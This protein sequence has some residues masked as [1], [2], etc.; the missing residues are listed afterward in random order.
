MLWIHSV[1]SY[2][3]F[4]TLFLYQFQQG[5]FHALMM[6]EVGRSLAR[7]HPP[8]SSSCSSSSIE[9]D[10]LVLQSI[11]IDFISSSKGNVQVHVEPRS[12]KPYVQFAR[13]LSD[14]NGKLM[15]EGKLRWAPRSE[16]Q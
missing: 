12:Q 14:T 8:S 9:E 1:V 11:H 4:A 10:P 3:Q 15:S 6:E 13:L 7:T 2:S 5:G 16:L